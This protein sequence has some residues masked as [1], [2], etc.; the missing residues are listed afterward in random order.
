MYKY[1]NPDH[2]SWILQIEYPVVK[3]F[4]REINNEHL[5]EC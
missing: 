4:V 1:L 3:Y 2:T 5:I